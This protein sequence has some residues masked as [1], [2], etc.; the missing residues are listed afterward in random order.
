MKIFVLFSIQRYEYLFKLKQKLTQN[1]L[2]VFLIRNHSR[3]NDKTLNDIFKLLEYQ[4]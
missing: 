3:A 1:K 4:F 2:Q